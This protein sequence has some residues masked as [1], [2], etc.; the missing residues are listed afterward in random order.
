M[1]TRWIG[2][3]TDIDDHK[4][5]ELRLSAAKKVA[6]D[7]NLAKSTFIANM[8][9][10][11]R[12]PL[13]AIIGYSEMLLEEIEDGDDRA[14]LAP[15]IRKIEGNARHLLGLINDV[16]DL[17]KVESG[18]M[19]VFSETFEIEPMLRDLIAAVGSLVDKK[20]NRLELRCTPAQGLMHS[21]ITKVRQILLNLLGNAAKFTENGIITL[22]A[23]RKSGPDGADCVVFSVSDT[24]IG[25]APEQLSRLFGRFQQADATTTRRFGGTGLG[26]SLIKAF[27]DLLG[28]QVAVESEPGRGSTFTLFLP[29]A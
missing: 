20:A 14:E 1:V 5:A 25:I 12:T 3:N 26:L 9:H 4:H 22:S 6:E 24:G 29:A 7:A 23:S 15:D 21:D 8:S 19:E 18:K 2:T 13:S 17:S 27:A 10:E 28:G 11:L 16:L